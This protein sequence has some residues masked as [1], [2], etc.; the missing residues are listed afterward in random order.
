MIDL[1]LVS[2]RCSVNLKPT[3]AS[4]DEGVTST[5]EVISVM[6]HQD[7]VT[8]SSTL[9]QDYV[10][11]CDQER[12][13]QECSSGMCD[14]A[15]N[16][17]KDTII[18]TKKTRGNAMAADNHEVY[19][20]ASKE[21]AFHNRNS[22][23]FD[24]LQ[25]LIGKTYKEPAGSGSNNGEYCNTNNS[26]TNSCTGLYLSRENATTRNCSTTDTINN[27]TTSN[28]NNNN[29]SNNNNNSDEYSNYQDGKQL[30]VND[31]GSSSSSG[32]GYSE[33]D[34]LT[35]LQML[36]L[37]RAPASYCYNA[38]EEKVM[39]TLIIYTVFALLWQLLLFIFHVS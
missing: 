23:N 15:S 38:I 35:S 14:T 26:N 1:R 21:G 13:E 9:E 33:P 18:V 24:S 25:S 3:M 28:N 12:S 17:R 16:V 34:S 39:S 8:S 5:S 7:I 22:T 20:G 36:C 10:E 2:H 29:I 4:S 30:Q 37:R 27:S 11:D 31:S 32:A 6:H 19:E